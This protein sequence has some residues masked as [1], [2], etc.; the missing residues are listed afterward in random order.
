MK[1]NKFYLTWMAAALLTMGGCSDDIENGG[2]E[3]P[4]NNGGKSFLTVAISTPTNKTMT[5][6]DP[7]PGNPTGGEDGDGFLDGT[8]VENQIHDVN[9]FLVAR[10]TQGDITETDMDI[11]AN[12]ETTTAIAA[13]AYTDKIEAPSGGDVDNHINEATVTV[14]VPTLDAYYAVYAITNI[15]SPLTG[16]STLGDLR[17][18]LIELGTTW[19]GDGESPSDCSKFVMSTHQMFDKDNLGNALPSSVRLTEENS[20]RD[21][22]AKTTVYV[23]R[24]AARIDLKMLSNEQ[25]V[26]NP[27]K[28]NDKDM[29]T[30]T[31]QPISLADPM[32]MLKNWGFGLI[33]D[34]QH[35]KDR[36]IH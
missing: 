31:K 35:S 19:T 5:K 36:N 14:N 33:T 21:N 1:K 24:L 10:S 26:E 6:A 11:D 16:I 13:S 18:R 8:D 7:T 34:K 22:A 27:V 15:G 4:N 23:E 32:V 17:D 3:S 9:I 12:M 28:E 25:E 2:N 20:N 29:V 30:Y